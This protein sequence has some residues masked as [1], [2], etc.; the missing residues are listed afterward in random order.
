MKNNVRNYVYHRD[1]SNVYATQSLNAFNVASAKSTS[2]RGERETWIE[3]TRGFATSKA[4]CR[5]L[6]FLQNAKVAHRTEL[7]RHNFDT[8]TS[9]MRVK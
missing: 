8:T 1:T 6:E 4:T 9:T 3:A 7:L 5:G 2:V